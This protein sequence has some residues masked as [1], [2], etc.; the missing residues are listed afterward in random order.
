MTGTREYPTPG[1]FVAEFHR[2]DGRPIEPMIGDTVTGEFRTLVHF[3][4]DALGL[5]HGE[6]AHLTNRIV[7]RWNRTG[8]D[9]LPNLWSHEHKCFVFD[10]GEPA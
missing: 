1:R 2:A 10:D 4:P 6:R 3:R 5:S 7:D 9:S 8:V